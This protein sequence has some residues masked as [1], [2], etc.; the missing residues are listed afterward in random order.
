M[1]EQLINTIISQIQQILN[2]HVIKYVNT[3]ERV[4]DSALSIIINTSFVIIG[5]LIYNNLLYFVSCFKR[6]YV[7]KEDD[8]DPLSINFDNFD[9]K[10]YKMEEIEQYQYAIVLANCYTSI[11][12][13]M[14][15][16]WCIEHI[17]HIN[18][19]KTSRY[20]YAGKDLFKISSVDDNNTFTPVW[21]YKCNNTLEY[22]WLCKGRL[23]SN[24]LSEI[25]KFRD[26]VKKFIE[27]K[28][29]TTNDNLNIHEYDESTKAIKYVGKVNKKKTFDNI[30]FDEKENLVKMLDKFK[31]DTMYPKSLGLDNKL[32]I[33]LYGPGGTG[34]T[35]TITATANYLK[36][37]ILIINKLDGELNLLLNCIKQYSKTHILVF[38]EFD[39]MLRNK[40]MEEREIE[41]VNYNQLLNAC[42]SEEERK[43]IF[44]KIKTSKI[45]P[46]N[47]SER[48][49]LLLKFLDGI[50]D[51]EGRIIIATT[52]NPDS[53]DKL[54]LRPGR[55]DLKL[56][57]G[58]CS[59]QMIHDIVHTVYPNETVPPNVLEKMVSQQLTPLLLINELLIIDTFEHFVDKFLELGHAHK[60]GR[61]V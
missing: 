17:K 43:T 48:F 13:Q 49:A 45:K 15:I 42:E 61:Q 30:Y 4:L 7:Y 29:I 31:T 27:T 10:K 59:S 11:D 54:L 40:G 22:V 44:E 20:Y 16:I 50:E 14:I 34:K 60:A 46:E 23:Y 5:T 8:N 52:N 19:K 26:H 53:I 58:Y 38:D 24:N 39:R 56:S 36:K 47:S 18:Q 37:H 28:N 57:L 21:K 32:G 6:Q 33:F 25:N 9:F 12:E 1:T 41:N 35:G 55:F 51:N 2:L 3:G